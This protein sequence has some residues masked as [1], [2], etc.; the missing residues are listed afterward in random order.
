MSLN[1][2][3][4]QLL[5][6][7]RGAKCSPESALQKLAG[8]KEEAYQ[9][10]DFRELLFAL[11]ALNVLGGAEW[12]Q[13]FTGNLVSFSGWIRNGKLQPCV[14]GEIGDHHGRYGS[15]EYGLRLVLDLNE[16]ARVVP[17]NSASFARR[18]FREH[19]NG[20]QPVSEHGLFLLKRMF[21]GKKDLSGNDLELIFHIREETKGLENCKGFARYFAITVRDAIVDQAGSV[22]NR[23]LAVAV[24]ALSQADEMTDSERLLIREL[25]DRKVDLGPTLLK[26]IDV[27]LDRIG[28]M[29]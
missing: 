27:T 11:D 22:E 5:N 1:E 14:Y 23:R 15:G 26:R 18:T 4:Q 25:H 16:V 24:A 21:D 29:I 10:R 9:N 19:F 2:S 17:A 28:G 7:V 13:A 8:V 20:V 3:Q 12:L 6:A